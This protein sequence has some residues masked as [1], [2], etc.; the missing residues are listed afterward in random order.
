MSKL[1]IEK[2]AKRKH[3]RK[4][5][6]ESRGA[7]QGE[8]SEDIDAKPAKPGPKKDA[9]KARKGAGNS[10]RKAVKKFVKEHNVKIAESLTARTEAGDMRG[11]AVMISLMERK[12]AAENGR[13]WRGPS[14]AELLATGPEW[15]ENMDEE[16]GVSIG[17][18][19]PE[20]E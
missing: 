1:D 20:A 5:E 8:A 12:K 9:N 4:A 6:K 17:G 13:K 18:R 3:T 11:A 16:S 2:R 10:L 15:N 19:E 7:Q 14:V